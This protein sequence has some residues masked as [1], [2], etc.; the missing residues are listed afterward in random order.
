MEKFERN[1]IEKALALNLKEEIYGSFSEIGAGQEVAN[2]FFKAG[3]A[4]GTIA[5]TISA[6]DMKVS[7]THYGKTKRYVSMPRLENMLS[8]EYENLVYNL[9]EKA[10]ETCFFA[11]AN[12]IETINFFKNNQ[13]QGWLGI[14]FQTK[15]NEMPSQV[16]IH[17]LLHDSQ[18]KDQQE[19]IGILG[20]NIISHLF[21]NYTSIEDY[22][23]KLT[24][25]IETG[26]VEINFMEVS[27]PFFNKIDNRLLALLLVK[28]KHTRAAMFDSNKRV[29]QP[30]NALYK[31]DLLIVRGRF[32][33]PTLVN[34]NMFESSLD[35]L[36]NT[37]KIKRENILP[38]AE[39]TLHNLEGTDDN[40]EMQDF[41]DRANLLSELN[42]P[43]LITDF[44]YHYELT[45]YLNT[46]IKKKTTHIVLG[47]NNLESAFE[48]K[49]YSHLNGGLLEAFSSLCGSNSNLLVYPERTVHNTLKKL[50]H[51][52]V[53][54]STKH[55][56][57]YFMFNN[58]IQDINNVK[59]DVLHILSDEVL[60][61][62]RESNEEWKEMVP[63]RIETIIEI[64]KPF[65]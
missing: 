46:Y 22:I 57:D 44:K 1:T 34:I 48:E 43:V 50:Q 58:N 36:E 45:D 49:H 38:I 11:F 56:L 52:E 63:K 37:K 3:A 59:E 47:I 55:L 16:M 33:P 14:K 17:I 5:K 41:I 28:H 54:P 25:N 4:S 51:I 61:M 19:A 31:K 7:D 42:L 18:L 13:G 62:I 60:K 24:C 15:P 26:R 40:C 30:L 64:E 21:L 53:S 12:T 10:D 8:V 9:S 39:L 6:Y 20:V 27:G 65:I 29:L 2:N 32:R 23:K 35:F